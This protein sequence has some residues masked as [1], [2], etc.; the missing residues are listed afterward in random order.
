MKNNSLKSRSH[1]L[2]CCVMAVAPEE[3]AQRANA[4]T[5][6]ETSRSS[7]QVGG[8]WT[9]GEDRAGGK[10]EDVLV[11]CQECHLRIVSE[12]LILIYK[13]SLTTVG[14]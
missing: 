2:E 5:F 6:W 3:A 1:L 12:I 11:F 7:G 8:R 14:Y 13:D 4:Q 10:T 9:E